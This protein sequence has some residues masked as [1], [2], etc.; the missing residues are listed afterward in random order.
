LFRPPVIV[1]DDSIPWLL[2][3]SVRN[4]GEGILAE[5]TFVQRVNTVG[6]L[7]PKEPGN[8]IGDVAKSPYTA[9]YFFYRQSNQP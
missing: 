5:V 8:K 7:A 3:K 9:D 6:G 4:E 1:N 2:L